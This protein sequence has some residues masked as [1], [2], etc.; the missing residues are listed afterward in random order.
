M[1]DLWYNIYFESYMG[2]SVLPYWMDIFL[3]RCDD[4]PTNYYPQGKL[5]K[6]YMCKM[7]DIGDTNF[8]YYVNWMKNVSIIQFIGYC[9]ATKIVKKMYLLSD[10][11]IADICSL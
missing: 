9:W 4:N 6:H 7:T 2:D 5:E 8:V 3:E 10:R 11:N 1:C